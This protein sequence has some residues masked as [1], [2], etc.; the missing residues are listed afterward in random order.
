AGTAAATYR[1]QYDAPAIQWIMIDALI[2]LLSSLLTLIAMVA[3]VAKIDWS[4]ALVSMTIVPVL[5]ALS[6]FYNRRLKLQWREVKDVES[7]TMS[8]IEEV[9]SSVRVVKA[10]AQ[11]HRDHHRY[12]DTPRP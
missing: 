3:V 7:S 11:Q 8:V 2:P 1:M 10:F 6:Q 12:L 4:L 9:L 5:Y